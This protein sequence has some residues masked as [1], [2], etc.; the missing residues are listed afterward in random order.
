MNKLY[1]KIKDDVGKIK[2][3]KLK[4]MIDEIYNYEACIE[5]FLTFLFMTT[6]AP[7][8]ICIANS[9]KCR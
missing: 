5:K 4:D 8:R 1:D 3:K 9:I 7:N 2:R 6:I